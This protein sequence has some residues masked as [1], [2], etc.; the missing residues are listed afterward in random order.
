MSRREADAWDLSI[1]FAGQGMWDG[2]GDHNTFSILI[3]IYVQTLDS[4]ASL[5][6][7]ALANIALSI[8]LRSPMT[9]TAQYFLQKKSVRSAWFHGKILI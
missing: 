4:Q 2:V 1:K 9:T 5:P 3:I 8:P 6:N 7:I